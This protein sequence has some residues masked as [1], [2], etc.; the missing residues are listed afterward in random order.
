MSKVYEKSL[1]FMQRVHI[2]YE[3]KRILAYLIGGLATL[4]GTVIYGMVAAHKLGALGDAG[5]LS[6]SYGKYSGKRTF[7][8]HL[9]LLI[10]YASLHS[11]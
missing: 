5:C 6:L 7:S 8:F 1:H 3:D 4:F 9:F 10:V 11:L 2:P